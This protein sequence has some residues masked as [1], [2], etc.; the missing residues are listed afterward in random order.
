[1]VTSVALASSLSVAFAVEFLFS[2]ASPGAAAPAQRRVPLHTK[3]AGQPS[4]GAEDG[5][6]C[7]S[8]FSPGCKPSPLGTTVSEVQPRQGWRSPCWARAQ[9]FAVFLVGS[10]LRGSRGLPLGL[11]LPCVKLVTD[12]KT[13]WLPGARFSLTTWNSP[14]AQQTLS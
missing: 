2:P 3:A 7:A 9:G 11:P 13:C 1:M 6:A 5:P 12:I 14:G 10:G 8:R 4:P